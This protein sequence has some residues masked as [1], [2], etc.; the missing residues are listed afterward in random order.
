MTVEGKEKDI[1][2]HESTKCYGVVPSSDDEK[3]DARAHNE[4]IL[5]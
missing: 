1:L 5:L 2:P 4:E 3:N